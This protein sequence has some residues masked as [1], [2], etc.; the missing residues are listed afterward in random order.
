MHA[1]MGYDHDHSTLQQYLDLPTNSPTWKPLDLRDSRSQLLFVVL[2]TLALALLFQGNRGLWGPDEGRFSNVAL[3]MIESGNWYEPKRHPEFSEFARPPLT[4]WAVATS[5]LV[6]GESEWALRLPSALSFFGTTLLIFFLGQRL[7]PKRPWLPPLLYVSNI[8]PFCA[9]NMLTSDSLLTFFETLGVL[10]FVAMWQT[11][12]IDRARLWRRL[13][14]LAFALA[15]LTKG[16]LALLPLL[17][18]LLFRKVSGLRFPISMVGFDG[19]LILIATVFPWFSYIAGRDPQRFTALLGFYRPWFESSGGPWFESLFVYGPVLLSGLLPWGVVAMVLALTQYRTAIQ[20]YFAHMRWER[21]RQIH[22]ESLFLLIWFVVP[23]LLL[24]LIQIKLWLYVLPVLV[25]MSLVIARAIQHV[26]IKRWMAIAAMLW[27]M[28]LLGV[29]GYAPRFDGPVDAK[30][31]AA[32]IAALPQEVPKEIIAVD[33]AAPYGL[34]FYLN[35]NLIRATTRSDDTDLSIDLSVDLLLKRIKQNEFAVK[36]HYWIVDVGSKAALGD[37]FA[38]H[39]L[40]WQQQLTTKDY[41]LM[42]S[43]AAPSATTR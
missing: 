9:A 12:N 25:P 36:T 30:N 34:K 20:N 6:F 10:A 4:Y 27:G 43:G 5:L 17:A 37:W 29:K 21:F 15:F 35:V 26:R 3:Q 24:F 32:A 14:W 41:A 33:T 23:L 19:P 22:Q 7:T 28:A 31:L 1:R 39:G 8:V 40:V 42:V 2:I 13:M 38:K 18:L 11:E 16:P